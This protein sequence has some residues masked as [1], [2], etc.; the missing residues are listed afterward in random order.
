MQLD[1]I[2]IVIVIGRPGTLDEVYSLNQLVRVKQLNFGMSELDLDT[3]K[4]V[5][6]EETWNAELVEGETLEQV[7]ERLK[8]KHG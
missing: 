8:E 3:N 7:V 5:P 1:P 2:E 4:I 6:F